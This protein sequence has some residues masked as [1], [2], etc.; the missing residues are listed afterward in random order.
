MRNWKTNPPL[1][2]GQWI[3][4]YCALSFAMLGVDAAMNHYEEIYVNVLSWTPLIFAPLAVLYCVAAIF[5]A[6]W[7]CWAW[8]VG[9]LGIAV[10]LT[11]TILHLL[12]TITNRGED[13]IWTALLESYRPVLAPAS[14]AATAVLLLLV[15]WAERWRKV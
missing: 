10:G 4:L 12:P 14:F 15:A 3:A 7:R 1:G 13:T 5:S 8:V 2:W 11:G 9:L 6:R